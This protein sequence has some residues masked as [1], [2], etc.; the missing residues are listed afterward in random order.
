VS[1]KLEEVGQAVFSAFV[2]QWFLFGIQSAAKNSLHSTSTPCRRQLLAGPLPVSRD[3]FT[4]WQMILPSAAGLSFNTV[5]N[6]LTAGNGVTVASNSPQVELSLNMSMLEN[7]AENSAV[8]SED[9]V[10]TMHLHLSCD[11]TN[12]STEQSV[13]WSSS[14]EAGVIVPSL[15]TSTCHLK[16]SDAGNCMTSHVHS[17]RCLCDV[18][19]VHCASRVIR[20]LAMYR[21]AQLK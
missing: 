9:F 16:R 13:E 11:V 8:E 1:Y 5:V 7:V 19:S 4:V 15:Q 3:R 18:W 17:F 2:G 12:C 14:D 20:S 6:H 21:V 10:S